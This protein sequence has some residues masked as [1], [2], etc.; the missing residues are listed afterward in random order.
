MIYLSNFILFYYILN[1][2]IYLLKSEVIKK[3]ELIYILNKEEKGE[4][5]CVGNFGNAVKRVEL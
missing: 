4:D 5:L 1:I 2:F 3:E